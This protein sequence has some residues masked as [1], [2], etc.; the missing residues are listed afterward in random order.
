MFVLRTVESTLG[1]KHVRYHLEFWIEYWT[2]GAKLAP[3]LVYTIRK[4]RIPFTFNYCW[5][6]VTDRGTLHL[7]HWKPRDRFN[8]LV[9]LR[10]APEVSVPS[11]Q[12]SQWQSADAYISPP[13]VQ[14]S[15][16]PYFPRQSSR[17]QQTYLT[18]L[19]KPFLRSTTG[20]SS[21]RS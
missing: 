17:Q 4:S 8:T 21:F 19:S 15:F 9:M 5:A 3:I 1:G 13:S 7:M 6:L 2:L 10:L 12:P 11:P 16:A 14:N 20:M 18:T